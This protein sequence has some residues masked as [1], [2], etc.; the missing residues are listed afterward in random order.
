MIVC[1]DVQYGVTA[2]TAALVGWHAWPDATAACELVDRHPPDPAPYVPGAFY[3][4]ELPY[5]AAII[6]RAPAP[7]TT[8][9]I[10]GHVWLGP[11][12]GGLGVHVHHRFG[13]P[14]IGVA[15]SAFV[16]APA[17]PVVRGGS[18]RPLHVTAIGVEPAVAAAQLAAM[19]GPFRLPTLIKRADSLARGH[20]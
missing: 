18:A 14:V 20:R 4:R 3:Q 5:L 17:L 8:I 16:G 7:V 12:R 10:D 19:H 6:A 11:D 15:K 1:V 13:V 9:V 2:V